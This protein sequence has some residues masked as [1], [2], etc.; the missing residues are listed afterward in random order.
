[1]FNLSSV[2][3]DHDLDL[4]TDYVVDAPVEGRQADAGEQVEEQDGAR[5]GCDRV[6]V[7]E[8]EAVKYSY[9]LSSH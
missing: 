6:R 1:M 7:K 3:G 4:L 9:K 8:T 5:H 2:E